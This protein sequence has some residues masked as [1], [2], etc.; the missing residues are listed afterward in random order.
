MANGFQGPPAFDFYST[1]SGLGDTLQ[2]N[3]KKAALQEALTGQ[4][5]SG[6]FLSQLGGRISGAVSSLT[7]GE[8]APT[9]APTPAPSSPAAAPGGPDLQAAIPRLIRAGYTDE[10]AKLATI[11]KALSPESSADL[12]AYN[13]YQK[14]E[15]AAGRTPMPFL[16]FKTKLAEAGA[17]RVNNSTSVTN[18]GEK[19]FDKAVGKDYGETFVG[20]N[21][22]ARD[23]V[24]ALNNLNL[25]EKI[26]SDPNFYSGAGGEAVT[27]AKQLAASLGIADAATAAPNE[28]FKKISQ[29]SV[30]DAAGGSLGGGFSNADRSFLEG[31][32]ANIGNTPEGNR[33]IIGIARRVEQRKQEVAQFARDYAKK[34]GGRIDAGFDTALAEWTAKNPAFP[35]AAT[36]QRSPQPAPQASPAQN[37]PRQAPDGNFYVPDPNRPGKYLQVIQ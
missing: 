32:V 20:I 6:N 23:S 33:Q 5:P 34:N 12:Q 22:A 14:Q 18:S 10:A 9:P 15:I 8:P 26:T 17:T 13:L 35:Q 3:Q 28:L 16:P 27:K 11:Q 21:K 30:L 7:G 1:L 19:E 29:K 2:A 37:A 25:M 24:G 4:A 36:G 31:T